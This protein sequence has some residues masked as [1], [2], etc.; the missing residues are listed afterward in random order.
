MLNEMPF[1]DFALC[2]TFASITSLCNIKFFNNYLNN[3]TTKPSGPQKIHAGDVSRLGGLSIFLTILFM[4]VINFYENQNFYMLFLIISIPVFV[5]S[6][7]EDITQSIS[8]NL[9]LLGSV[10]SSILFIIIS[11]TVITKVGFDT[12]NFVL[13]YK[14]IG[15]IF[16]ILCITYLIQAFNIIDGLNGLS[17]I[18]S[19]LVFVSIGFISY[20]VNE[21]TIF[22]LS[23][24][25]IFIL[26]GVLIFNFPFGKIFLG[27]SGAYIIG[28]YVSASIIILFEKN[29]DLFPFVVVQILIYP[30]YELLRSFLRRGLSSKKSIFQPDKKHL[31][32]ILYTKNLLKYSFS[33]LKTNCISSL[34]IILIQ[35]LNLIYILNFYDNKTLTII[36]VVSFITIYEIIYKMT[37]FQIIKLKNI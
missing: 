8:P 24:S 27:D 16:T 9:R 36:G 35:T 18:T 26:F 31:H 37:S 25:L 1:L 33:R 29:S 28:L 10:L 19:I 14:L 15:I 3:Y 13:N 22:Y 32:S 34:Q 4:S 17:L 21:K 2:F 23:I 6:F 30:S 12:L 7:L 11:N 5:F 20:E